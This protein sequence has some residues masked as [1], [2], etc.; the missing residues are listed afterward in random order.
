MSRVVLVSVGM[1]LINVLT[2]ATRSFVT[3]GTLSWNRRTVLELGVGFVTIG[4]VAIVWTLY[5]R[6]RTGK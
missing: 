4:L 2:V 5:H 1:A 6:T 3:T